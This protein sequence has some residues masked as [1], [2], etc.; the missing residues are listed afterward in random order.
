M[1]GGDEGE[2]VVFLLFWDDVEYFYFVFRGGVGSGRGFL[3]VFVLG[4]G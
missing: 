2:N 1:W 3:G 4:L